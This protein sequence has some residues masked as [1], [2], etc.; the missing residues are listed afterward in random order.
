MAYKL[1]G[2]LMNCHGWISPFWLVKIHLITQNPLHFT[3]F[4]AVTP[5][6]D[7]GIAEGLTAENAG[8]RQEEGFRIFRI[9]HLTTEA[10]IVLWLIN[11]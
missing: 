7:F 9:F 3:V 6:Q 1:S 8:T 5:L 2:R 4:L 11:S 10:H